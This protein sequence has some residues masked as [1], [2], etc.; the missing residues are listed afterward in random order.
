[1]TQSIHLRKSPLTF[2]VIDCK[3]VGKDGDKNI[4]EIDVEFDVELD[5]EG[6]NRPI[7]DLTQIKKAGF[8]VKAGS[9]KVAFQFIEVLGQQ[10]QRMDI[11]KFNTFKAKHA[12]TVFRAVHHDNEE[13][14]GTT[15]TIFK[16]NRAHNCVMHAFAKPNKGFKGPH[17]PLTLTQLKEIDELARKWARHERGKKNQAEAE[18][19]RVGVRETGNSAQT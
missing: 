14:R 2:S 19:L 8:I 1:M 7:A 11:D 15:L 6:N 10:T 5:A 3:E 9:D 16:N 18:H 4:Y 13:T 17:V 12:T